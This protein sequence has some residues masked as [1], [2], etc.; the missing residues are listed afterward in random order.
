MTLNTKSL[1]LEIHADQD[2][3]AAY[4]CLPLKCASLSCALVGEGGS[5]LSRKPPLRCCRDTSSR[6]H[7][8]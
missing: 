6:I 5:M 3:I 1:S 7:A 2:R 8:V 4:H